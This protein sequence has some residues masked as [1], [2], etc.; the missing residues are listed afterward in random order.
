MRGIKK[1]IK[2]ALGLSKK[3]I[4]RQYFSKEVKEAVLRFQKHRCAVN[5]CGFHTSSW[6]YLEFDHLKDRD[7]NSVSNC[8]A[9]CPF[10]HRQ[11][12]KR[13]RIKKQIDKTL[14]GK[15]ART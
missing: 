12:T 11:K 14:N 2:K 6:R 4:K 8:Q 5:K 13:D 9:L 1:E 10:H 15:K 7:D 3:P